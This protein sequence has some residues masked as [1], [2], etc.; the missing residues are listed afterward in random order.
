MGDSLPY[1]EKIIVK[2]NGKVKFMKIGDIVENKENVQVLSFDKEKR[3]RFTN[4]RD[5]IKHPLRGKLLEVTTRTGRK[6]KVTDY[7]SLFS[8]LNGKFTDVPVSH[9]IPN[10]SYIAIPR[11]LNLPRE[12]LDSI[13]LYDYFK[14]DQDVFVSNVK[15]YLTRAKLILSLNKT[16]NILGISKKYLADI[17]GK[18]LP[19]SITKFDKLIKEAKLALKFEEIKIK[20]KGS[21]H[22]YNSIFAVNKDFW[23]LV[24]LWVAEGDLNGYTVRLHN[25]NKEIREDMHKICQDL[26]FKISS[27]ENSFAICSLFLQKI[28][29]KVLNLETG[30]ENKKIPEI[31]F[32]L[33]KESKANF[34]KGY[35]SG[36]GSNYPA[37]RGKFQIEASTIS[38]ELANGL[39]YLLLDFGIVATR[40]DKKERTGSISKR[41]SILGVKNFEKFKDAGFIDKKRNDRI[42]QY[43][44]SRKWFRSDLIPLTG[45]LY[46]LVTENNSSYDESINTV[47]KEKLKQ[48]LIYVDKDKSLYKDYWDLVDGD[49]FF[50]RVKE[51]KELPSEDYVYDISVPGEENFVAGFGGVLAH[52]SEKGIR[53][54]FERARQAA[55]SIIFFDEIDAIASA[56]GM[57]I[58]NKVTERMVN[59]LLTEMDGLEELTDVVVIGS[60][61]RPDL[62]DPA[63]LRPGRFDRIISTNIPEMQSREKIFEIHTKEMPLAK[64]VDIKKL[65]DQTVG[66]VGADIEGLCREAGLLALRE[67]IKT[68]E[69]KMKHFEQALEKIKPSITP[70]QSKKY[71]EIEETYLRRAK[72]GIERSP[73]YLG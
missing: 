54:V 71:K 4:L 5:H 62:L 12:T 10:E 73:S 31:L 34:L 72:A 9:L 23:R 19:V 25:Q 3:V 36:D 28:F 46:N 14:E 59:Q 65:V 44:K 60:T 45:E 42:G 47:C 11:N 68:T 37:A 64:D 8:F 35:F 38:D 26:G 61:N 22:E 21:I 24:G 69:V 50:D 52:N 18:D 20:L 53:K 41:I 43:I 56:R 40:Y 49:I 15:D 55:P 66:F 39:L 29:K 7:H 27:S 32:T 57:D 70:E 67:D 2:K 6:I 30:A 17:I 1:D 33:D 48:I 63:L 16:A 51:I 13:N 58:G